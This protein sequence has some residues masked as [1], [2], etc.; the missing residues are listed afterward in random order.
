MVCGSNWSRETL[1]SRM[2]R[3]A[4]LLR[5]SSNLH[6]CRSRVVLI[7][8]TEQTRDADYWIVHEK[9][10]LA[11]PCRPDSFVDPVNVTEIGIQ[12]RFLAAASPESGDDAEPRTKPFSSQWYGQ[13]KERSRANSAGRLMKILWTH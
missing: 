1:E 12:E 3:A 8:E 6:F 9:K 10:K 13:R 2:R 7:K 11:V 5:S 4:R